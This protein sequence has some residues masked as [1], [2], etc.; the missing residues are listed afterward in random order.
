MP[1]KDE[2]MQREANRD[3]MARLRARR[4]AEAEATNRKFEETIPETPEN[5]NYGMKP[6]PEKPLT[7]EEFFEENPKANDTAY[8]QYKIKW[9][10]THKWQGEKAIEDKRKALNE[11]EHFQTL[12][13]DCILWR[14]MYE[15]GKKSDYRYNHLNSCLS[16][17]AWYARQK[18][19]SALD[20]NDMKS[21]TDSFKELDDYAQLFTEP[22][23]SPEDFIYHPSGVKFPLNV[24]CPNCLTNLRANGTCPNCQPD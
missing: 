15:Q 8:I 12:N 11:R 7:K 17:S 2:Q 4:K 16:C 13:H 24:M 1:Y 9:S 23:G 20:L 19:R 18:N 14:R 21:R 5:L 6:N 10:Y 22:K 3:A